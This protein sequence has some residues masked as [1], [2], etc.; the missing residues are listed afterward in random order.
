MAYDVL[1]GERKGK[2]RT[3][4]KRSQA[5][6]LLREEKKATKKQMNKSQ[7]EPGKVYGKIKKQRKLGKR[8][9]RKLEGKD[10]AE[11]GLQGRCR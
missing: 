5:G 10:K 1:T 8:R 2:E 7:K 4:G 9:A 6:E 11:G 3:E